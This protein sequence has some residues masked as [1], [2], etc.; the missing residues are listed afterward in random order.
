MRRSLGSLSRPPEF[1][2]RYLLR[3]FANF[4]GRRTP[5]LPN[6]GCVVPSSNVVRE[7][8]IETTY[9][10][11]GDS[12]FLV[13]WDARAVRSECRIAI[14]TRVHARQNARDITLLTFS[15]VRI[16]ILFEMA[17][18]VLGSG[19]HWLFTHRTQNVAVGGGRYPY[20]WDTLRVRR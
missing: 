6:G 7:T 5:H 3:A 12:S 9:R 19:F 4:D 11:V 18:R 17:R 14:G 16:H 20:I 15:R 13:V 1:M 8:R 10:R 2:L